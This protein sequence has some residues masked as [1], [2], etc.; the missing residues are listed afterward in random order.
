M[1]SA[2]QVRLTSAIHWP[3]L[4]KRDWKAVKKQ[5]KTDNDNL[6]EGSAGKKMRLRVWGYSNS[7]YLYMLTDGNLT[8]KYKRYT[9]KWQDHDLEE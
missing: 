4:H 9:K 2:T 1:T 5:L 7:E 6:N 8:L 3:Q